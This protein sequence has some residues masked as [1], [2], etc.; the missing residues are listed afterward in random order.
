MGQK[1]K[2]TTAKNRLWLHKE[3]KCYVCCDECLSPSIYSFIPP[4]SFSLWGPGPPA[5]SAHYHEQFI[6]VFIL[7]L[8]K[9][10]SEYQFTVNSYCAFYLTYST[11]IS[12]SEILCCVSHLPSSLLPK[13]SFQVLPL[14]IRKKIIIFAHMC[15][16]SLHLFDLDFSTL[17]HHWITERL[18]SLVQHSAH[19]RTNLSRL[20]SIM[21]LS[22]MCQGHEVAT[23]RGFLWNN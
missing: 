13:R 3:R 17:T 22:N 11:V 12:A 19:N 7:E 5:N 2:T 10:L 1:N 18:R 14:L 20:L 21:S 9:F 4:F 15:L 16:S 23:L 8:S 6:F